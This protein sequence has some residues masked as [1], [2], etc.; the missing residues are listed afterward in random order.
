MS[1]TLRALVVFQAGCALVFLWD[2]AASILG[3]RTGPV[4]WQTRELIEILA[5][6][7]LLTGL[8]IGTHILM[9]ARKL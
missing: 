5:A 2:L 1:W 3:L 7:G 9:R 4:S 8:A 6:L